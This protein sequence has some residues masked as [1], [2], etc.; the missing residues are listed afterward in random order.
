MFIDA[1]TYPIRRGGWIMILTGALLSLLLDVL[2]LAPL[3]GLVVLIFSLG[4]FG[5]FYLDIIN[6]TMGGRHEVPDWP[7]FSN[8]WDDIFAPFARLFVLVLISFGPAAA[9]LFWGDHH[10]EWFLGALIGLL[11]YGCFYFPMAVLAA[12]AFGG[13]GAALPHIV[14]PALVRTFPNYFFA[15]GGLII[16]YIA[17]GDGELLAHRVPY[18]G[19][20]LAAAVSLYAL[21]FQGR[22]IG[23]IY[24]EKRDALGW[25]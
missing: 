1:L 11:G 13:V 12:Q 14:F 23:L 6:T 7:T 9:F 21:M 3:V 25:D 22:V 10:A 4:Y 5:A 20:L 18:V 2:Q 17:S 24:L 8:F 19:W 15:V 16:A